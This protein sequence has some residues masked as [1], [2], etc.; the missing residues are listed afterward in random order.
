MHYKVKEK[1]MFK[2][3]CNLLVV[4]SEHL[5]LCQ[6]KRLQCMTLNGN[7]IREW[8]MDS[9]IRYIKVIGGPAGHEGMLL[10]LKNGEVWKIFV[11]NP[12][13]IELVKVPSAVKC[14]D[15]SM[16]RMKLSVVDETNQV[17]V[18]D[19]ENKELLY[20]EPN[21]NSAAW[22]SYFEDI[23]CFSA[24]DVLSIKASNFPVHHQK[25]TVCEIFLGF[26]C[27]FFF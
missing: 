21:A 26:Y 8:V 10:G 4:C 27:K 25:L 5:V 17:H 13:P 22:N 24:N 12:F 2:L 1:I 3:E 20:Q 11:D 19:L 16:S 6:D 23:L 14:L 7:K 15:L 9:P 18:Y